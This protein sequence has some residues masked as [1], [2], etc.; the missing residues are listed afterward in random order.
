MSF[1]VLTTHKRVNQKDTI[2][3]KKDFRNVFILS[4]LIISMVKKVFCDRCQKEIKPDGLIE[5]NEFE[6]K[7]RE[8]Y[9]SFEGK[10]SKPHLCNKCQKGYEKIV[11][12]CEKELKDYI[13][14]K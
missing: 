10:E 3:V 1:C 2:Y 9:D 6:E 4:F 12:K 7:F 8:L 14:K 11:S 5:V 13:K